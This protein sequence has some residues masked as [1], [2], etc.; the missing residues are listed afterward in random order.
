MQLFCSHGPKL[1]VRLIL[2]VLAEKKAVRKGPESNSKVGVWLILECG[3]YY[4][5]YGTGSFYFRSSFG[6]D[7][8]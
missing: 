8:A 3:L 4:G 5:F 7:F 1:G 6:L 2:G